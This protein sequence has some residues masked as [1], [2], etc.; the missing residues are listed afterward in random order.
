MVNNINLGN[1]SMFTRICLRGTILA[2]STQNKKVDAHAR[3]Y[4]ARRTCAIHIHTHPSCMNGVNARGY[5]HLL[6]KPRV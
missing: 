6:T 4:L 2:E 5:V 3:L 1:I